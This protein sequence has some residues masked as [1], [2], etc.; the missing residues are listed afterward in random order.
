MN[1]PTELREGGALV[2]SIALGFRFL[3][4]FAGLIGIAWLFSNFHQVPADSQAVVTRFGKVVR[5]EGSGLLVALPRPIERVTLLPA[6][7]RQIPLLIRRF[8]ATVNGA[9]FATA[10]YDLSYDARLNGAFVLTGD[11]AVV[12]LQAEMFYQLTD[13]VAYMIASENIEPALERLFVASAVALLASRNLDSILVA[14]PEIAEQSELA[15][16]RERLRAD[17]VRVVNARLENLARQGAGL[18][19]T[20]SR[21]DLVPAI[22]GGAKEAFDRVLVVTQQAQTNI[23]TAQTAARVIAQD[24]N[25]NK[26]RIA[27]SATAAAEEMVTN[28]KAVT[29]P[30]AALA[31]QS[32]DASREMQLS[33][34]YYERIGRVLGSADRVEVIDRKGG[35][36]AVTPAAGP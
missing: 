15:G 35:I 25:R 27:M 32:K 24:A 5:V 2:Q 36:R 23:A 21:V 18:G 30:I 29:A 26:D 7:A 3:F 28:A 4:F 9:S 16:Q 13:P 10:G 33:R 11:S 22:P 20:V 17:L 6:A 34:I 19:V 14:R 31:A 1:T 8:N 12:H